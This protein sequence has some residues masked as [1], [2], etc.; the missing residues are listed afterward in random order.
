VAIEPRARTHEFGLGDDA[1]A[2]YVEMKHIFS[3]VPINAG[4]FA[5]STLPANGIFLY[6][7]LSAPG[8][9]LRREVA[10]R[11]MEAV[12][13]R[14]GR[15]S[16]SSLR[17]AGRYQRHFGLGGYDPEEEPAFIHVPVQRRRYGRVVRRPTAHQRLLERRDLET[18][19]SRSSNSIT[20]SSSTASRCAKVRAARGGI[21]AASG[22]TTRIRLLRGEAKARFFWIRPR[23]PPACSAEARGGHEIAVSQG[24]SSRSPTSLERRDYVLVPEMDCGENP[25]RRRVWAAAERGLRDGGRDIARGYY[26]G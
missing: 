15:R 8:R 11:I 2:I 25:G 23:W 14:W 24:G 13:G 4:C 9:R 10:Q 22:S 3:D 5:R 17:G 6:A 20:R 21:A 12:F 26:N 19:P 16:G 7:R 1:I 18:Q